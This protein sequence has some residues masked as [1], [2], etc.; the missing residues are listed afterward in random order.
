MLQMARGGGGGAAAVAWWWM[1]GNTTSRRA[2]VTM[3]WV[4][5]CV[6]VPPWLVAV[7]PDFTIIK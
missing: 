3:L 6:C 2:D 7:V 5:V 4:R 1:L